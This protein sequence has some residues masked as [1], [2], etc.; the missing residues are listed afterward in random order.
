VAL[1]E[2][3]NCAIKKRGLFLGRALGDQADKDYEEYI[4]YRIV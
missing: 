4:S 3:P 1:A 2:A